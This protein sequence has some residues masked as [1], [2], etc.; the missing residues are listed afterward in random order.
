MIT[1][2][3]RI[4]SDDRVIIEGKEFRAD[5]VTMKPI[6]STIERNVLNDDGVIVI[7][8]NKKSWIKIIK[9]YPHSVTLILKYGEEIVEG[10][11]DEE[12]PFIFILRT[13]HTLMKSNGNPGEYSS[14]WRRAGGTKNEI[15]KMD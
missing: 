5:G 11:T 6:L 7:K 4:T 12:N 9:I 3:V 10:L 2:D 13:H 14:A 8:N 15:T 1:T